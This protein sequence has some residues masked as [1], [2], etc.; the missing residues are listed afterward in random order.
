MPT[1]MRALRAL[2]IGLWL[3]VALAGVGAAVLLLVSSGNPPQLQARAK[4]D[5]SFEAI[6][7]NGRRVT[8]R[9]FQG[10]PS[11]WFF[12]FTHCPD[13]CPTT[14]QQLTTSLDQLGEDA[15]K[16]TVV[17]V[18]VDPER[19]TPAILKEYM[20]SFHPSIVALSPSAKD[21]N[22]IVKGFAAYYAKV[23]QTEGYTMEHSS[24]VILR[25]ADG[26]FAGTIDQH[27]Q[28]ETARAK[29][30]RLGRG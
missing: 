11:A 21:L 24:L 4:L 29:L 13:V 1:E 27:E 9:T 22:A 15:K 30:Q 17:F 3:L 26:T 23:P 14:L 2:R 8:E 28:A 7:Q 19:D 20:E 6:D 10:K 18:T 16:L 12:G 25:A 5:P